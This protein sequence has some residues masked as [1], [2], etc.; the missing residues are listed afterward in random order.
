MRVFVTGASGFIGSALASELLGA[1]HQVIGL[2]RSDSSAKVL[3]NLGAAVHRG[4][5]E[6]LDALRAGAAHSDATIHLGFVHD[7]SRFEANCEIDRQAIVALASAFEGSERPLIV[8]G[9]LAVL[10]QSGT[11]TELDPIVP[12]SVF[13][14]GASEEA[15]LDAAARGVRACI[16]RLP[17]VHDRMRQG[18]V[19]FLIDIALEKGVSAYAG[20]GENRWPAVH[21]LDAAHLYRLALEKGVAGTR[22]HAVGEE[23]VSLRAIAE[24]IGR[25]FNLP[26]RSISAGESA[27]HFGWLANFLT[28]PLDASSALTREWLGW[29]PTHVGLLTDLEHARQA[30]EP[31]TPG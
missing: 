8:T 19:T 22:Y 16:V 28:A 3:E 21:R 1:G 11:A 4:S 26:V 29:N 10:S 24:A 12:S 14:R 20:D 5:L 17:Q 27:A 25:R 7:F 30:D 2:A 31:I 6:D 18:L 23:G 9:G 13:P 15:A